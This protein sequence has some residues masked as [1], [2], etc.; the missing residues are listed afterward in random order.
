MEWFSLLLQSNKLAKA[1]SAAHT[2]LLKHPDD[3]MMQKNMAYYRSLPGAEEHIK[4]LETK[5]YEVCE[6][7]RTHTLDRQ[8]RRAGAAAVTSLIFGCMAVFHVVSACQSSQQSS[9][10]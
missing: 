1:V 7:A 3:D 9:M 5:S 6:R 2:F 10:C 4:D 8:W